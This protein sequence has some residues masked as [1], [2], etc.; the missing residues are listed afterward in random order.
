MGRPKY[1]YGCN[2]GQVKNMCTEL[3]K[4]PD[5]PLMCGINVNKNNGHKVA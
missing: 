1:D 5:T 2:K 4:A 3:L